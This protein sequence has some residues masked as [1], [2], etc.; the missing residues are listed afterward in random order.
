[1]TDLRVPPR[2]S[3]GNAQ[4]RGLASPS[5]RSTEDFLQHR[6][7]P[8]LGCSGLRLALLDRRRWQTRAELAS[9]IVEYT[10][11]FCNPRQ[12]HFSI[13]NVSPVEFESRFTTAEVAARTRSTDA[14]FVLFAHTRRGTGKY[15][16]VSFST[17]QTRLMSSSSRR[18]S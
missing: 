5:G 3:L 7:H 12:R 15:A 11:T 10:E 9:A 13:S 4:E 6:K 16:L 17:D 2:R 1:M 8:E 18:I 14:G